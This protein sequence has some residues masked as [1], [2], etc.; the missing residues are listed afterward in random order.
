M[1][2]IE[3][4]N[5][6]YKKNYTCKT[7]HFSLPLD[8]LYPRRALPGTRNWKVFVGLRALCG[9]FVL[10]LFQSLICILL[11]VAACSLSFLVVALTA[12]R[13]C[14]A[15]EEIFKILQM[16]IRIISKNKEIIPIHEKIS[17]FIKL[18]FE[19]N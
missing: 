11:Q 18:F 13:I 19:L 6:K 17:K 7:I 1:F 4:K 2:R 5:K 3:C 8:N 14:Q 12:S 15:Q 10:D 16:Q 9:R